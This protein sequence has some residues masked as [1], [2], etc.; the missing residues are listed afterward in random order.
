MGS[1]SSVNSFVVAPKNITSTRILTNP[2][3]TNSNYKKEK[4]SVNESTTKVVYSKTRGI[5]A[6]PTLKPLDG[7]SLFQ[8]RMR[9][10]KITFKMD[11][12][13]S[14]S[15]ARTGEPSFIN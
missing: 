3:T 10:S 6:V 8:N 7:N 1:C 9:N 4:Y 12:S 2:S 13:S 11:R 14:I 5:R 15:Q